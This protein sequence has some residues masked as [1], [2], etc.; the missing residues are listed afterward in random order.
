MNSRVSCALVSLR[1]YMWSKQEL[2]RYSFFCKLW[3]NNRK[4]WRS[5]DRE[6]RY[7]EA[8]VKFSLREENFHDAEARNVAVQRKILFLYVA[9]SI[10]KTVIIFVTIQ[11]LDTQKKSFNCHDREKEEFRTSTSS[12]LTNYTSATCYLEIF[13]QYIRE[14][15]IDACVGLYETEIA[16]DSRS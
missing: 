16:C 11:C 15:Q 2:L 1:A 13:N 14:T 12:I 8:P 7:F 4:E 10:S 5:K 9:C 6:V 3:I